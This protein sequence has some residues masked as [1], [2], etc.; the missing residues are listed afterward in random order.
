MSSIM[1]SCEQNSFA[2]YNACIQSNYQRAPDSSNVKSL[3]A[4]LNAIEEDVVKGQVTEIKAKALAWTAY[5]EAV[6]AD[7]TSEALRRAQYNRQSYAGP[8]CIRFG[9]WVD[10]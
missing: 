6:G 3:Y 9:R 10:C 5:D 1:T 4:R 8:K 7:N 2:K